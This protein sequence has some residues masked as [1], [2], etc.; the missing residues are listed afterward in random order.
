MN[1]SQRILGLLIYDNDSSH[2]TISSITVTKESGL[3]LLTLPPHCSHRMQPLVLSVFFPFKRFYAYYANVWQRSNPGRAIT[4][5]DVASLSS[6]AIITGFNPKHI[7]SGF[8][9]T[10]IYPLNSELFPAD[11][12]LPSSVTNRP[13]EVEMSS[14]E[15][16]LEGEIRKISAE[17]NQSY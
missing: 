8:K 10:G 14:Q 1:I 6:F 7:K 17:Q 4:I 13:L 16:R 11:I 15:Y 2:I 9:S 3:T 12:F 5:H